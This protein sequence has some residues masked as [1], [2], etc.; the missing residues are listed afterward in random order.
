MAE[1]DFVIK[2]QLSPPGAPGSGREAAVIFKLAKE[3]KPEVSWSAMQCHTLA[4]RPVGSD[5]ITRTQWHP[6]GNAV[7]NIVALPSSTGKLVP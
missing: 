1:D 6:D 5:A 4:N 2:N 3:L 7:V